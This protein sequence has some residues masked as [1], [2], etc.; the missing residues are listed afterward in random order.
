MTTFTQIEKFLFTQ[1][2]FKL[3]PTGD[4]LGYMRGD[5]VIAIYIDPEESEVTVSCQHEGT[6]V[7]KAEMLLSEWRESYRGI[8]QELAGLVG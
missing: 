2:G 1:L 4:F 5:T 7:K 8:Y 6:L 3:N